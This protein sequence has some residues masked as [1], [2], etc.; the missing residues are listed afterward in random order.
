MNT[1]WPFV[2]RP[3]FS[4]PFLLCSCVLFAFVTTAVQATTVTFPAKRDANH[5]ADSVLAQAVVRSE[6]ISGLGRVLPAAILTLRVNLAGQIQNSTLA[7]GQ[8]VSADEIVGYLGGVTL[9][10]QIEQA[11]A[12]LAQETARAK[13]ASR[14]VDIDRDTLKYQLSTRKKLIH[15]ELELGL[16]NADMDSAQSALNTLQQ[17][18]VLRAPTHGVVTRLEQINGSRVQ[19]GMAIAQIEPIDDLRLRADFYPTQ[20][21]DVFSQIRSGMRGWFTP[22]GSSQKVAVQVDSVLPMD[23]HDGALPVIFRPVITPDATPIPVGWQPGVMGSVVLNGDSQTVIP[24]PTRALILERGQWWVLIRKQGG[25]HRQAVDIG[26]SHGETTD[27]IKGLTIG[28][29]VLVDQAYLEFHRDFSL[30]Y[31]QP[32]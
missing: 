6:A 32:D 9:N 16:A 20:A 29:R 13:A 22:L 17:E 21:A 7:L 18:R 30:R 25:W 12:R 11:K 15:A 27:V 1:V 5:V 26:A 14:E 4:R 28:E 19:P 31:Q 3:L 10:A 24:I 8:V 23:A 2:Q